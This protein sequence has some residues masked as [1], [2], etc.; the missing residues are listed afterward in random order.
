M[1]LIISI[2]PY[3]SPEI[4]KPAVI[5][6]FMTLFGLSLGF[7]LLKVQRT[8][9]PPPKRFIKRNGVNVLNPDYLLWKKNGGKKKAKPPGPVE[10]PIANMII[11]IEIIQAM[12]LA[13]KDRK[14]FSKNKTSDPYTLVKLSALP[15]PSKVSSRHN[16]AQ[17]IT[18]GRT[19]TVK[20]NLCPVW[21]HSMKGAIPYSRKSETLSLV[22]ELFDEDLLK[23]DDALGTVTLPPLEW[24]NSAGAPIWYDIPKKS[25]K[26]ASGKLQIKIST[27]MQRVEGLRS[28]C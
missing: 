17:K 13:A 12:D 10:A 14:F 9:A 18:L 11:Q 23:S 19:E 4:V 2:F 26:N 25:A 20:K 27:F 7:A 8:M 5:I 15:P 16:E 22:F 1:E 3:A 21:N 24:K 28:Y 6:F